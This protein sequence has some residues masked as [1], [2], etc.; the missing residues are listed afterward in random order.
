M[1]ARHRRAA[2]YFAA[3]G[4]AEEAIYH[5]LAAGDLP[6][7]ADAIEGAGEAALRAGWLDTVARWIDALPPAVLA[8]HPLLQAFLGD[9]YRLRSRFDDALAWYA[10]AEATWRAR[11][12]R[13]GISRALR[14]QALV[15]LDTVRPAQAERIL[16]EALRLADGAADTA[17]RAR[18]LDLLAENKLNLGQPDAAERLR[19]EARALREE[20]PGEDT[21]SVRVKLRTGQLDEAQ[22]T[23]ESWAEAER[24]EVAHGQTHPPRAHRETLLILSLIHAFR[25]DPERAFALAQEGRA[26]GARLRSPFVM[27]VADIRMGHAWQLRGGPAGPE[28]GAL[29]EAVG[30]YQ[31]AIA[32]GDRMAVRRLRAEAMWGLTRAY[33]F[34]GRPGVG[35]R[36][37]RPKAWRPGAGRAT[38]GW[39]RWWNWRW[40]RA[41]CWR[42][43]RRKRSACWRARSWLSATAATGWGA[44]RPASGWRWPMPIWGSASC[45]P[46]RS[47]TCC[48][49]ASG[50]ATTSC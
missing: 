3:A 8:D 30:C 41:S 28:P 46:P 21:L 42:G 24:G 32:L 25:G 14:G 5:W 34:G 7:A 6:A 2:A 18:L 31:A 12:D 49:S 16:E 11:D 9:V 40:G 15:Y 44:R 10:Q 1:P 37:P 50:T 47:T 29:S 22:R 48:W 45:A 27:A 38:P 13:A 4:A 26:V 19:A 17:A 39:W 35:A 43:R 33:G 23:L 20:G 36:A